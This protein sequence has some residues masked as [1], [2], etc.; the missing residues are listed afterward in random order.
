MLTGLVYDPY[1]FS[2]YSH[3]AGG[4]NYLFAEV[5]KHGR[6]RTDTALIYYR[7][8][9]RLVFKVAYAFGSGKCMVSGG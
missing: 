3:S 9:D 8:K 7:D 6:W 4:V 2:V 1:S 5:M